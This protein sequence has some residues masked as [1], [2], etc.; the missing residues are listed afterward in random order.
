M[1]NT[2]CSAYVKNMNISDAMIVMRLQMR[3]QL[4]GEWRDLKDALHPTRC[5]PLFHAT[6]RENV[7]A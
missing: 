4:R 7:N 3:T 1:A 6:E 5:S 2:L